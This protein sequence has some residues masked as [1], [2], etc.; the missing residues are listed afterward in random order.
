MHLILLTQLHILVS[1]KRLT[2]N[3]PDD[4]HRRLKVACAERDIDMSE[5]IRALVEGYLR[6]ASGSEV[7]NV[8]TS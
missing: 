2:V 3:L 4:I 7:V 6:K 1:M 8:P 5:V